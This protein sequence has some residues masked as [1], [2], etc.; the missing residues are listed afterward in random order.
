[1]ETEIGFI[2]LGQ[3]GK[4]MALNLIRKGFSL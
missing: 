1:M 4:W 3:M 2:G